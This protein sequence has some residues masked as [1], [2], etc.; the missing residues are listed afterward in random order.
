MSALTDLEQLYRDTVLE[1]YRHP[2]NRTPLEAPHARALVHNPVC[3]DQV[4]V[5]LRLRDGAIEVAAAIT[6]GCSIAVASGSLM[7]EWAPGRRAE[8]VAALRAGLESLVSGRE[9][10]AALPEAFRCFE[11]VSA[12]PSRRRC[13]LLPW[14]ALEVALAEGPARA[15][16]AQRIE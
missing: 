8:D 7:T 14:E 11:R 10:S 5:E 15:P 6:R 3:G 4:R 2:R 13:A 1:H 12:L 16:G 9:G